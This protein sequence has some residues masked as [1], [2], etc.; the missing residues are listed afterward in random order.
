MF[1]PNAVCDSSPLIIFSKIG[2]LNLL[3][4]T[5][6]KPLYIEQAVYEE[7]VT[8]GIKKKKPHATLIKEYI[9]NKKIVVKKCKKI[10][11]TLKLDLG[12]CATISLALEQ[13]SNLVCLDEIDGRT[14][15][16]YFGLQPIG[17]I[18]ILTALLKLKLIGKRKALEILAEMVKVD[19]RISARLLEDF[20]KVVQE[21]KTFL[22]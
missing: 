17:C 20:K 9:D 16:K 11:H 14:A 7:V 18:G 13:K 12:E 1:K 8:Q 21:N 6:Q 10:K 5:F 15:A 19:Y 2:K 3:L 4:E 22:P